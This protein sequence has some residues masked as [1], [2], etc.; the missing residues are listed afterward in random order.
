MDRGGYFDTFNI[1]KDTFLYESPEDKAKNTQQGT[2]GKV[3]GGKDLS[4]L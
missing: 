3:S 4:K 1:N 2:G